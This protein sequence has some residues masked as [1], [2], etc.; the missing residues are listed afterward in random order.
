MPKGIHLKA[1]VFLYAFEESVDCHLLSSFCDDSNLHISLFKYV[2][3]TMGVSKESISKF[4]TGNR[5]HVKLR[6]LSPENSK[7]SLQVK[8]SKAEVTAEKKHTQDYN[9]N[10]VIQAHKSSSQKILFCCSINKSKFTFFL[11]LDGS[12]I[13]SLLHL[14]RKVSFS[15]A[16]AHFKHF[17][18]AWRIEILSPCRRH[19]KAL[20]FLY[21]FEESADCHLLSSFCDCHLLS[22]F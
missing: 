8:S 2:L 21:A 20:V 5:F 10:F 9:E 12:K 6:I 19:L 3:S 1:L 16:S 7:Q 14:K 13:F 22:S 15:L 11:L 4:L 17:R 18:K